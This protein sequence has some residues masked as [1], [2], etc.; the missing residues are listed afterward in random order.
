MSTPIWKKSA[1]LE[2]IAGRAGNTAISLLGIEITEIG[3]DFLRATMP[4]DHRHVQPWR[5]LHGGIS[6]ALSETLGSM[7]CYLAVPEG[8]HCVGIEINANHIAAV[9]EGQGVTAECRPFHLGRSTQVWQTEIRRA[10]G[11]LACVSRITCAVL[12]D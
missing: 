9:P 3:P 8:F 10:D 5:V 4:V 6:V 11:R 7:A 12:P 1:T 2:Q